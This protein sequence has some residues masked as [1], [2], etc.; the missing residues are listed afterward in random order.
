MLRLAALLVFVVLFSTQVQA[1]KCTSA[2]QTIAL[3]CESLG[4]FSDNSYVWTGVCGK[5]GVAPD[6]P[7]ASFCGAPG[8]W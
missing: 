6:T 3:C 5:T 2:T 4:E 1:Q 8:T 7:T